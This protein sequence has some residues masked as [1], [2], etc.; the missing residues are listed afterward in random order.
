MKLSTMTNDQK[1]IAIAE[2]RGWKY[3]LVNKFPNYNLMGV[4]PTSSHLHHQIPNYLS[5]LNAMH[6][7]LKSIRPD[8]RGNPP[9]KWEDWLHFV[10]IL[11]AHFTGEEDVAFATARQLADAFLLATGVA[12]WL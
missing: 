12:E 6:E 3:I 10:E 1:R 2:K 11:G 8:D 7:A 9:D 4:P 5:D